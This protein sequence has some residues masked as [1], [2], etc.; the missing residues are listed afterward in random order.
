[1]YLS[2]RLKS[3]PTPCSHH[4]REKEEHRR[5]FSGPQNHFTGQGKKKCGEEAKRI[6]K[7]KKKKKSDSPTF[8]YKTEGDLV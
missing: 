5:N 1:M 3:L 8:S 7:K 6:P 4:H 2:T